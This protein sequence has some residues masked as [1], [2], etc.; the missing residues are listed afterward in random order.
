MKKNA[1]LYL[2]MALVASMYVVGLTQNQKMKKLCERS[3]IHCSNL[4]QL[5]D[6]TNQAYV[7][8][9]LEKQNKL[10]ERIETN[11]GTINLNDTIGEGQLVLYFTESS[12]NPCIKRELT[13]VS[14]LSKK[15][16]NVF[17][18]GVFS[19]QRELASLLSK[20]EIN[21]NYISIPPN[22]SIY[23]G[24][25]EPV[26]NLEYFIVDNEHIVNNSFIPVQRND[27][28]SVEYLSMLNLKIE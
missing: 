11:N 25:F 19:T 22:T 4:T 9:A 20:Y 23:E 1:V 16:Y 24:D 13:N 17:L 28:L 2:C 8:C 6:L 3:H 27:T 10:K 5:L 12:W 26:S 14:K 18:I 21:S 15:G 7:H